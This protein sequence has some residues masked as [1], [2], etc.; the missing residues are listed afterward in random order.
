MGMVMQQPNLLEYK[1]YRYLKFSLL[2]M[3]VAIMAY[4]F[5]HPDIG[6]YGG[7]WL[8]YILGSIGA[9]MVLVLLWYG[10]HKRRIPVKQERRK[11]RDHSF[12]AIT[13]QSQQDRRVNKFEPS[14]GQVS[15]LQ[16]W[17]SAHVYFGLLLIVIITLHTGFHFDW[18]VQTVAYGLMMLVIIT[19]LYGVYGYIRFPKQITENLRGETLDSLLQK[20]SRLDEQ[21]VSLSNKLPQEI[22]EVVRW[23]VEATNIGGGVFEQLM[24]NRF[25]SPTSIA[26][27]KLHDLATKLDAS[28]S[29]LYR[30]LYSIIIRKEILENRVRRDISLR[31]KLDIWLYLHVPLSIAL[32]V[33]LAAHIISI[34]FYW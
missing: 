33:A 10:I 11:V 34:Y 1:N 24:P 4:A 15:T 20:I 23:A 25:A 9:T 30:E 5:H 29:R 21:G 6:A 19:G 13:H 31:A 32:V 27:K 2:L 16:G 7:T 3:G 22:K 17:L 18:N 12:S 14:R 8:G 26:V 28:Q